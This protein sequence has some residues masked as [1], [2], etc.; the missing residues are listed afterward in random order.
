MSDRER[1]SLERMG[2]AGDVE[3]EAHAL[4]QR[5]RT[6]EI[7]S[8]KFDLLVLFKHPPARLILRK[9]PRLLDH[10]PPDVS[11]KMVTHIAPEGL[12]RLELQLRIL[13]AGFEA[14]FDYNEEYRDRYG[15][16][17]ALIEGAFLESLHDS[18]WPATPY[19]IELDEKGKQLT[20]RALMEALQTGDRVERG[21]IRAVVDTYMGFTWLYNETPNPKQSSYLKFRRSIEAI[22]TSYPMGVGESF[23]ARVGR[24]LMPW[25]LSVDR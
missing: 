13:I 14:V 25:L 17:L 24:E 5:V 15:Q 20:T 8:W 12:D 23:W 3:A 6:G 18:L 9:P 7:P 22:P 19:Q 21:F 16:L 10:Y 4:M 2:R 11:A 1:R